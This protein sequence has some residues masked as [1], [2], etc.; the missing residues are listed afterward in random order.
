MTGMPLQ[1]EPLMIPDRPFGR[2]VR[3]VLGYAVLTALMFLTQVMLVFMPAA[4]FHCGVR[5]GRRA[6]WIATFA[7]FGLALLAA[8]TSATSAAEARMAIAYLAAECLALAVP[9]LLVL[10]LIA[11]RAPFGSVLMSSVLAATPG[12]AH[13]PN[14]AR[15]RFSDFPST[16]TSSGSTRSGRTA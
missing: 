1:G 16:P 10:P 5:N 11:R 13:S 14:S 6:A 4:V 2:I 9:A 7:G 12:L 15:G 3:S 8:V